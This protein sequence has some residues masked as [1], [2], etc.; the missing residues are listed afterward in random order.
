MHR[1]ILTRFLLNLSR[2]WSVICLS[3]EI[4][5]AW[6]LHDSGVRVS[7][8]AQRICWHSRR[9]HWA[10]RWMA[11]LAHRG[12]LAIP[13]R[14]IVQARVPDYVCARVRNEQRAYQ[15][16]DYCGAWM[17]GYHRSLKRRIVSWSGKQKEQK[18]HCHVECVVQVILSTIQTLACNRI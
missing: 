15:H 7:H 12:P 8:R 18:S 17:W 1:S 6:A 13:A 10:C 16:R 2:R 9:R 11:R 3:F 4:V 14:Q 5:Q